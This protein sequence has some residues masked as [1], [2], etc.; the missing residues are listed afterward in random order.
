[1][2]A[3]VEVEQ[4]RAA[5]LRGKRSAGPV[6]LALREGRAYFWARVALALLVRIWAKARARTIAL[7]PLPEARLFPGAEVYIRCRDWF[8]APLLWLFF[9][10]RWHRL[11]V[12][13]QHHR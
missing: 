13:P 7:L 6:A 9:G 5:K 3:G 2:L 11:T 1:M 8:V 10:Y 4:S 12:R